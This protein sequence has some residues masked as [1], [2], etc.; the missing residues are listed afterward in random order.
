MLF[1]LRSFK[2]AVLALS[3]LSQV[4]AAEA[5]PSRPFAPGELLV[6]FRD[7]VDSVTENTTLVKAGAAVIARFGTSEE[8]RHLKGGMRRVSIK[9]E[10]NAAIEKLQDDPSVAFV[11]PNYLVHHKAESNDSSYV[12]GSLWGAYGDDLPLCGGS[13]TTN[14]YGSDVEEAWSRGFTGSRNVYVGI[15][16][17]GFQTD[18]P[19]LRD[20]VWVNPFDT[21]DGID[22]DKNGYVDDT[23]GWDFFNGDNSVFDADDGDAHGTHVAG[24]IGARGG[25][26]VGIAGIN[27][28]VSLVSAKFL[29]TNGGFTSDAID[30]VDYLRDLKQRHGINIVAINNSWGGGG[31][32]SALHTAIIKAAKQG[33]LFV[34]A[35]GNDGANNDLEPSYPA[36]YSSLVGTSVES[37]AT[38]ESVISVAAITRTGELASFSNFG[39]KSVD[40]G[41]PGAAIVS[42]IPD[43]G[44]TAYNG[45]SMAAP[46]VSGAV[47]L[48]ASAFPAAGASD[49]RTALLKNATMTSSLIGKS[50]AGGRL[51]LGGALFASALPPSDPTP[52]PTFTSTPTRTPTPTPTRT[53]TPTPTK[54]PTPTPTPTPVV[55]DGAIVSVS[56]PTITG[57]KKV[58]QVTIRVAN[59]GKQKESFVVSLSGSAGIAEPAK[60]IALLAGQASTVMMTWTAP[61]IA[62]KVTLKA[63]VA[64]LPGETDTADNS[65][66]VVVTV[67]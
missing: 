40:I 32:S 46:H 51:N 26:G 19:E 39:A 58:S 11:E 4:S 16:D 3:F 57:L 22:N 54:T 31:Y 8:R 41:A 52:T 42:T 61:A 67:K 33:I 63:S 24:T 48:Y 60:T 13:G 9:G 29:G 30:A 6:G 34:V 37:P 38:Y 28:N 18:H 21:I 1:R 62:S 12:D 15:I 23:H 45:T 49:I 44:Y 65:K 25:N 2:Y 17:E 66:S 27:W 47:A 43:G 55:R 50:A 59:E 20:N 35:A 36:N 14:V 53:P 7:D 10:L 5:S 56:A 64:T